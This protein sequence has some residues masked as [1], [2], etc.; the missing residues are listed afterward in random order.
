MA[1]R[2]TVEVP[3]PVALLLMVS[4]PVAAPPEVGSNCTLKVAD[5][6][7]FRVAGK[8]IPDTE[9]T[10]PVVAAELTV[11]GAVPEDVRVM[12]WVAGVFTITFP[13]AMVVALSVS[14]ELPELSCSAKLLL[15][16]PEIAV[17]VIV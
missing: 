7:G 2:L 6:P 14:A 12:D 11:T 16:L 9:K 17:N 10:V 1:V 8:V 15:T 13:N 3:F 5:W 4:C